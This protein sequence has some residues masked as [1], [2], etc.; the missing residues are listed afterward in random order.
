MYDL[1]ALIAPRPQ[2]VEWGDQDTSR[3]V[4]PA[5]SEIRRAYDLV[6]AGEHLALDVFSGGHFFHGGRSLPWLAE[7]LGAS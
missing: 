5:F 1:S 3:P 2:F 6:G 7:Q 4:E